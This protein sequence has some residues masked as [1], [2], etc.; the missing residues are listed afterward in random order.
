VNSLYPYVALQDMPGLDCNKVTY[1]TAKS[2]D[3]LF[4]FF[5]CSIEAPTD[6]YLGLLAVRNISG[7]HFPLGKWKG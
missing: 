5:Y 2:I 7:I 3:D 4:G 1:N 6:K